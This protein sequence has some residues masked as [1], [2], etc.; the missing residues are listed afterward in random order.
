MSDAAKPCFY[1]ESRRRDGTWQKFSE[2][3]EGR[4]E[5]EGHLVFVQGYCD[6]LGRGADAVRLHEMSE[7]EVKALLL[8]KYRDRFAQH[9][10]GLPLNTLREIVGEG[11]EGL[12][13]P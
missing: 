8:D 9:L 7:D 12:V 6:D 11:E 13:R 3:I 5:A 2:V 1:I 4:A 10:R